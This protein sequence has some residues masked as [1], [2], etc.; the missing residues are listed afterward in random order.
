MSSLQGTLLGYRKLTPALSGNGEFTLAVGNRMYLQKG[1]EP[2]KKFKNSLKKNF[3]ATAV[4]TDFSA[5]AAAAKKINGWVE[6]VTQN[7]IKDFIDPKMLGE[8]TKMV[9]IN[10]I[11]FKGEWKTKFDLALTKEKD[12]LTDK[13]NTV[14]VPTMHMKGKFDIAVL[15]ELKMKVLRLPYK[16]DR[17]VMTIILPDDR[18][19]LVVLEQKLEELEIG[20]NTINLINDNISRKEVIVDLPKFK[21]EQTWKNLKAIL[22]LMGITTVF[23]GG[24]EGITDG[25]L[26]VSDVIQK[27]LIEVDENGSE[28]AAASAVGMSFRSNSLAKEIHFKADHPFFFS[29]RDTQTGLLLFKGRLGD[30][31]K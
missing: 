24:L 12:F 1:L 10:A 4:V 13:G 30:P 2:K 11:Y 5:S 16:G 9:L 17:I 23:N 29:L 14:R 19:G 15:E 20:G 8:T 7:K 6:K 26:V 22:K 31:S 27:A 3:N 28:A 18:N 21:L 25:P